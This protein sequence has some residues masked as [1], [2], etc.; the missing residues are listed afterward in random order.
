M[1]YMEIISETKSTTVPMA[2][3]EYGEVFLYKGTYYIK[4]DGDDSGVNCIST[5]NWIT[6]NMNP[7]TQVTSFESKL[8]IGDIRD[9]ADHFND[10][11]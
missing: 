2:I 11:R 1:K 4:I 3:I 6:R 9:E 7:D 10:R 5:R 8:V